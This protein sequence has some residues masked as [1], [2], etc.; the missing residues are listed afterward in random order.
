LPQVEAAVL[1]ANQQ[2]ASAMTVAAEQ[3]ERQAQFD[4]EL[5]K[6]ADARNTLGRD[7]REL[8]AALD[9]ARQ[10]LQAHATEVERL[11]HR[12]AAR[13]RWG[14]TLERQ[15]TDA[16]DALKEANEG[17]SRNRLTAATKAAERELELDR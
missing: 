17:A 8:Q 11:T 14:V 2:H 1:E 3:A 7:A 12:A 5:A 13:A 16:A 9:H 6:A 4:A 15:L 10:T